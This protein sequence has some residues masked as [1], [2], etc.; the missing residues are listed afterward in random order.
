ME[1]KY[2]NRTY[3]VD[4]DD[5][6]DNTVDE[7]DSLSELKDK[8][9]ELVCTLFTIPSRTSPSTIAKAK[10]LGDWVKLAPH[11]YFHTKGECIA[12]TD[13]EAV[14][15]IAAARAMGIDEEC[16]RAPAWLLDD[17]TYSACGRM[18]YVLATHREFR[19][20][21]SRRTNQ[22]YGGGGIHEYVYNAPWGRERGTRA[23]HGHLTP[24]SGNYIKDMLADGRLA[25]RNKCKFMTCVDAAVEIQ[26]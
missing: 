26:S 14:D 16:F 7:L 2:R 4:F 21:R 10:A 1:T 6:C 17:D 24:V 8:Y 18:G 15:K 9:P 13:T 20:P 3:V 5:F 12:W 22:I 23:V 25:F 11:G 19:I